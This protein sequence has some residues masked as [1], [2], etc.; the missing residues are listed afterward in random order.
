MR[1]RHVDWLRGVAVLAMIEWHALDA[2]TADWA[3]TPVAWWWV[4][5]FGGWAAPLFVF[6][7]GVSLPLAGAARLARGLDRAAVARTLARRGAEIF[8]LAHLFRVQ[9]FLLNGSTNW[10]SILK[11]DILNVLGL[12]LVAGAWVWRWSWTTAAAVA[13]FGGAA[14]L[15]MIAT[16]FARGWAWPAL[17]Y[18]RF[19]AY[20]RPVGH[21][22]VFSLFPIVGYL[23]AGAAVG[24]LMTPARDEAG[25]RRFHGRT[26]AVGAVAL[27]LSF[28]VGALPEA[29]PGTAWWAT[30][31]SPFVM[32]TAAMSVA[33]AAGWWWWRGR[34]A[35]RGPLL[36]F[37]R[38]S[39][40]VY[41]IHV[42][43]AYGVVSRPWHHALSLPRALAAF[44]GLTLLMLALAYAWQQ[45]R[46]SRRRA[47]GGG[48]VLDRSLPRRSVTKVS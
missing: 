31:V 39:L 4:A 40:F 1:L 36:T 43:V 6:L 44:A 5:F 3:R 48:Q 17:L 35:T 33:L 37:G 27:A 20:I 11:P 22:G 25:D 24:S 26:A 30:V 32:R 19:E 46:P 14:L 7:A 41:W 23:F 16:P 34:A 13:L 18:P 12:G 9:S 2:W 10:S 42:E 29:L 8:V 15:A 45:L 47:G 21:L 38:T 28:V